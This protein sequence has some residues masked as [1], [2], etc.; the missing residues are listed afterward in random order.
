MAGLEH[1]MLRSLKDLEAYSVSATDG[2]VGVVRD[3]LFDDRRWGVRYLVV[4]TGGFLDGRDVLVTPISFREVAWASRR[5]HLA[6]T[7]DKVLNSPGV[8]ADLPVSGQE[9]RDYFRYFGYPNYWGSSGVWGMDAYP[10]LLAEAGLEQALAG[11]LDKGLD[12]VHLRSAGTVRGYHIQATDEAIGHVE[13]FIVDDATWELRYLVVDTSNW[14]AGKKVLVSPLWANRVSWDERKVHVDLTRAQ[15]AQCPEW[16][17][18]AP[19]NREYETRLY[20]YY[21]RPAYWDQDEVP[22]NHP[23][24]T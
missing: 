13:D 20:D 4:G 6:L 3:F 12:D 19:V 10:G 24:L 23:P 18:D 11:N 14:W 21:G 17:P 2:D 15:I 22:G 5:F 9:E 16:T 1:A 8:G 7:R